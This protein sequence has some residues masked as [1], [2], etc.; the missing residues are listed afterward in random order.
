MLMNTYE[1]GQKK[2]SHILGWAIAM[3]LGAAL[4]VMFAPKKG[5][6][7][8]EELREHAKRIAERFSE[9]KAQVQEKVKR[10]FGDVSDEFERDYIELRGHFLAAVNDLR[11]SKERLTQRRY[12]D[13]VDEVVKNSSESCEQHDRFGLNRF[14]AADRPNRLARLCLDADLIFIQR[15]ELRDV[16][17]DLPL[18]GTEFGAFRVNDRVEVHDLISP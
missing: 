1:H 13:M 5:E 15:K 16:S 2:H 17:G 11:K 9:T 12:N 18:V 4:G 14:T 8:R 7:T 3:A 6:E 10:V